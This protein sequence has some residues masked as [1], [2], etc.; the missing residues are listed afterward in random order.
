MSGVMDPSLE[1]QQLASEAL[2]Y[3]ATQ[4]LTRQP[5]TQYITTARKPSVEPD[6]KFVCPFIACNRY[7][8]RKDL[9]KRH[10]TTLLASPDENHQDQV[11]WEHVRNSGVMTVYTRPRNLT[12]DQKK[13][14]R[15]ESNL[16]HRVKYASELK[17]KRNRKRR[18]EKLLEGKQVGVQTPDWEAEARENATMIAAAQMAVEAAAVISVSDPVPVPI[19][20]EQTDPEPTRSP[21][22][23]ARRGS[24][25]KK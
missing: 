5:T 10:L 1:L 22:R 20:V 6:A 14:R 9:L 19:P 8:K 12:E 24:R 2:N 7:Y 21:A 16:R 15:K 11:V 18:V 23:L 3:Q 13:Q 25:L 4:Q 17:E